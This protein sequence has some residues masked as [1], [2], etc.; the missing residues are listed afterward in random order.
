MFIAGLSQQA[1]MRFA[2][3][4]IAPDGYNVDSVGANLFVFF[5]TVATVT[6]FTAGNVLCV[7]TVFIPDTETEKQTAYA[8]TLTP[9]VELCFQAY[10]ISFY[11]LLLSIIFTGWGTSVPRDYLVIFDTIGCASIFWVFFFFTRAQLSFKAL[12]DEEEVKLK[13]HTAESIKNTSD[14]TQVELINSELQ[15]IMSG[16]N[17]SGSMSTFAAGY[18]YYNIITLVS[19]ALYIN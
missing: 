8:I 13:D 18:L 19:N 5:A 9:L 7:V 3:Y 17:N 14:D 11:A 4:S 15:S 16:L 6:A 2:P 12:E 1:L 10:L